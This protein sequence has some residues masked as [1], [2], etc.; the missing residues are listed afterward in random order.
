MDSGLLPICRAAAFAL[1]LLTVLLVTPHALA[2]N[3][4]LFPKGPAPSLTPGSLCVKPTAKRYAEGILYCERHVDSELKR[5]IMENYD[6]QL[7]YRVRQM[8]RGLF[9]IDHF[10]PL[11]MGGSNNADNLWPQHESVY[12]LTD[13]LEAEACNKMAQGKLRQATAVALIREAKLDLA[14][15]PGILK[16]I[17]EL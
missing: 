14:R 16:Q 13:Q 4:P 8:D 9:K 15:A 11:C 17:A 7:G 5:D 3:H 1:S 10:I 2:I 12:T 6:R